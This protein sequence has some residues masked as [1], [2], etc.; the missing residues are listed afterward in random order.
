[1]LWRGTRQTL[2]QA[3]KVQWGISILSEQSKVT[4]KKNTILDFSKRCK[5][6]PPQEIKTLHI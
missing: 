5:V 4:D 3:L 2:T 1:M 6:K